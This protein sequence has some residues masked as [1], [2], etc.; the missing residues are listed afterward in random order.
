MKPKR[1]RRLMKLENGM[2]SF[3]FCLSL[4]WWVVPASA[5]MTRL[6]VGF[7]AISAEVSV[8]P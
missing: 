1:K 7:G 8:D 2:V 4:T 3:L 5:Q 6:N